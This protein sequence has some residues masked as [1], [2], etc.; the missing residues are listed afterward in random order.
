MTA[1]AMVA[2]FVRILWRDRLTRHNAIVVNATAGAVTVKD[3][4]AGDAYPVVCSWT[5]A[6]DDNVVVLSGQGS[7]P[8]VI[9]VL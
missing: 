8:V 1:T 2:E 5:V 7:R 3:D 4:A 6:V 9:A